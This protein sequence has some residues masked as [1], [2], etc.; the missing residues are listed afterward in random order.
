MPT[1]FRLEKT[2]N[3]A[4]VSSHIDLKN[5]FLAHVFVIYLEEDKVWKGKKAELRN[6]RGITFLYNNKSVTVNM[7][8]VQISR[9]DGWIS[10]LGWAV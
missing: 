4:S 5:R 7:E 1:K 8:Q 10:P 6:R 3:M 9:D 2:I